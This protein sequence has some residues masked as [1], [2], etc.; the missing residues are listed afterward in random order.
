MNNANALSIR[1]AEAVNRC[2]AGILWRAGSILLGRRA[3]HLSHGPDRWD[4]PGGRCIADETPEE[5]LRRE[6][7]SR[8]GVIP[9]TYTHL[10]SLIGPDAGAGDA[11]RFDVFLV[12]DWVGFPKRMT[13]EHS[14]LR[15]FPVEEA[16]GLDLAHH[17]YPEIF[18][19]ISESPPASGK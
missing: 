2:S 14:V 9:T 4:I 17:E 6:L 12:T 1:G 5:A 15:W 11:S 8:I 19:K 10:A 3:S 7:R 13:D 16:L 18:R